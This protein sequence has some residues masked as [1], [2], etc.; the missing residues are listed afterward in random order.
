MNCSMLYRM[1]VATRTAAPS[2]R[3]RGR[4]V[5][6]VVTAVRLGPDLDRVR[7]ARRQLQVSP[8]RAKREVARV[9]LELP[10]R[11]EPVLQTLLGATSA[12]VG[13][14]D[15]LAGS[16]SEVIELSRP[17]GVEVA[18]VCRRMAGRYRSAD[19]DR[20]VLIGGD[21]KEIEGVSAGRLAGLHLDRP[22]T[23][24][25][26]DASKVVAQRELPIGSVDAATW[27]HRVAHVAV[28]DRAVLQVEDLVGCDRERVQLSQPQCRDIARPRERMILADPIARPDA[29]LLVGRRRMNRERVGGGIGAHS[30]DLDLILPRLVEVNQTDVLLA[31][32]ALDENAMYR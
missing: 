23:G 2:D 11:G 28:A 3:L 4:Q 21:G 18:G 31:A 1:I 15:D 10:R 30:R 16:A 26:L 32:D 19:G 8:I 7:A 13:D 9:A 22:H 25:E 12:R 14:V 17:V 24:R 5:E 20:E 27:H 6:T 29:E